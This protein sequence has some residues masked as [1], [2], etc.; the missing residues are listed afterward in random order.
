MSA[1]QEAKGNPHFPIPIGCL[2]PYASQILIPN[3]FLLCDGA[4]LLRADSP[5]LF[6]VIGVVYG[7]NDAQHF[8]LPDLTDKYIQGSATNTGTVIPG[9]ISGSIQFEAMTTANLPN[10]T[11]PLTNTGLSLTTSIDRSA[12]KSNPD[13]QKYNDSFPGG[14]YLPWSGSSFSGGT[15]TFD[16]MT[17]QNTTNPATP[18]G[19]NFANTPF[20]APVK[21]KG[22]S[23]PYII[24][25]LPSF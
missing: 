23:M 6:R 20:P 22:Y 11:L 16:S 17:L 21:L 14:T 2:L 9:T 10:T 3:D 8:N 4:E 18:I 5:D 12:I 7:S 13:R 1:Q 19:I 15:A 24:K 25:A